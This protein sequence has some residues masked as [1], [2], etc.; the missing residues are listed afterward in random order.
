MNAKHLAVELREI[1]AEAL[2]QASCDKENIKWL[3]ALMRAIKASIVNGSE[4]D[5][6]ALAAIG[7]YIAESSMAVAEESET[8]LKEKLELLEVAQ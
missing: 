5:A 7:Q 6:V 8:S 2:F 3:G 1:A 4:H